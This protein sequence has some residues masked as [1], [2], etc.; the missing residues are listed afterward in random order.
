MQ[1]IR[2]SPAPKSFR[3]WR[4]G[5]CSCLPLLRLTG[6]TQASGPLHSLVS[7][8]QPGVFQILC[9]V[10]GLSEASLTAP[11]KISAQGPPSACGPT[12][13]FSLSLPPF[14]LSF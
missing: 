14:L 13:G 2:H 4:K 11:F 12:F 10:C 1:G 8:L 3:C 5:S 7:F 9:T 6:H